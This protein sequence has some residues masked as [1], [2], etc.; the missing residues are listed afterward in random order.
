M[1]DLSLRRAVLTVALLNLAWFGVEFGVAINIHSVSLFA[2]SIDFLEDA[3]VNLLILLALGWS[4]AARAR[5]GMA[6]AALLM[7]PG[8]ATL[9]ALWRQIASGVAPEATSL[10]L[11]GLGA[12]AIN[13]GCA[14]LLTRF[15][16]HSGS[17]T[18]AAF[19]S[20][21]NDA[22]ANIAIIGAGL[23]TLIWPQPWPDVIVG[24][25]IALLNADAARDV[26][27]AARREQREAA[28]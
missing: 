25:G 19:L 8:L 11:T 6:M 23:V 28:S 13:S 2:D 7:V 15:R 4:L 5:A 16:D 9:W 22:Y 24:I 20:A 21:R 3:S 12:L 1:T 27:H 18:R 14:L 10:T 26:W 17:L